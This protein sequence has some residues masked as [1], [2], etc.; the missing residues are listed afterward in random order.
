[1]HWISSLVESLYNS[2]I[3]QRASSKKARRYCH[4]VCATYN[5]L[6][7]T[8]IEEPTRHMMSSRLIPLTYV[9]WT[10]SWWWSNVATT[11]GSLYY[12]RCRHVCSTFVISFLSAGLVPKIFYKIFQI[13]I[14]SNVW[15]YVWNIK[16]R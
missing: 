10:H 16:Y 5:Y 7:R 2:L 13:P 4:D 6:K 9:F 3:I 11:A 1:L 12:I 15:S 8:N 14:I